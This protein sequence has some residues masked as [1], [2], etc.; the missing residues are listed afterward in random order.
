MKVGKGM[1]L[2]DKVEITPEFFRAEA[3]EMLR[4][5]LAPVRMLSRVGRYILNMTRG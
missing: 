3:R 2:D 4:R 5:V 1:Q